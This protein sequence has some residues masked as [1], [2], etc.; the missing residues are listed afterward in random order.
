M[1]VQ[2]LQCI[3]PEVY[4][5]SYVV[6]CSSYRK[7]TKIKTRIQL[8]LYFMSSNFLSRGTC[9]ESFFFVAKMTKRNLIF[10]KKN[11]CFS[12]SF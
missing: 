11:W 2:T 7:M 12:E 3:D 6:K 1:P 8:G 5:F 10:L 9:D 4:Y